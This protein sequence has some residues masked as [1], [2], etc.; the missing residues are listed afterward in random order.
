MAASMIQRPIP[1]TGELLPVIGLGTW[2][3][4]D[5]GRTQSAREP[6]RAVLGSFVRLEG[7]V[8][9][10]S[11]MYG[12]SEGVVGDLAAELGIQKQLFL[13]T[14]VWT[15]GRDAGIQQ[16]EE[17]FR[18]LRTRMMDLMQVHNLVDWRTHVTTLRRWKEQGKIRPC[19]GDRRFRFCAAQLLYRRARRRTPAVASRCG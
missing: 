7:K 4:F 9:D 14:K 1:R 16:M 2:Q 8:I 6:L 18:R 12:N 13:A 19:A 15:S 10:S 5:V 17:S 3:T 11:P